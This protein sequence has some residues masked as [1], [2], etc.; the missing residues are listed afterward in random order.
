MAI[1]GIYHD[2]FETQFRR[3]ID[4]HNEASANERAMAGAN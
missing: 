3:A 1:R 4:M 2:L